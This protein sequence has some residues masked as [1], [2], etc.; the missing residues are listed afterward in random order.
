MNDITNGRPIRIIFSTF[1]PVPTEKSLVKD[2]EHAVMTYH[3]TNEATNKAVGPEARPTVTTTTTSSSLGV[4]CHVL[5]SP[6]QIW[7]QRA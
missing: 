6:W 5:S 4:I 2:F 3:I 7:I 1:N